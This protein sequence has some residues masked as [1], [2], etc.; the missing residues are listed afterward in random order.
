ML[1]AMRLQKG[2]YLPARKSRV[3]PAAD[4]VHTAP[5]QRPPPPRK[6][7]HRRHRPGVQ[8][9]LRELGGRQG[10]RVPTLALVSSRILLADTVDPIN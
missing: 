6:S 1:L 5:P 8:A 9:A 4:Q 7:A 2:R 10:L 3:L